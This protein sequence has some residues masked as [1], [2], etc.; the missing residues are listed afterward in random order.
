MAVIVWFRRSCISFIFHIFIYFFIPIELVAFLVT[1]K[2]YDDDD[3]DDDDDGYN[4]DST[5][6]RRPFDCLSKVI[7]VTVS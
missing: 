4:Y 3:D 6:V 7:K 5:V 1:V 2:K